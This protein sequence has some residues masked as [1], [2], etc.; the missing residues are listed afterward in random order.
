M[1]NVLDKIKRDIES[2]ITADDHARFT[3]I[4]TYDKDDLD[5][6]FGRELAS[7]GIDMQPV[8][9]STNQ[10]NESY[11]KSARRPSRVHKEDY[12]AEA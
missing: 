11:E 3:P 7:T 1:K 10:L 9:G 4:S 12:Y 8:T 6:D 2:P 5:D